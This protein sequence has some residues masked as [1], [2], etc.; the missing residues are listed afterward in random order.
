MVVNLKLD[1]FLL[2]NSS[3]LLSNDLPIRGCWF[4]DRG[5][6][7]FCRWGVEN[8]RCRVNGTAMV[9]F[10][11]W[12]FISNVNIPPFQHIPT[13]KK[14]CNITILHCFNCIVFVFFLNN[15]ELPPYPFIFCYVVNN[16]SRVYQV[17]C[18]RFICIDFC[19]PKNF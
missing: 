17:F 7:D 14:Q 11:Q 3:N 12:I 16:K 8:F 4:G 9:I 19:Y 6:S 13:L 15:N 2:G 10:Q 1:R 5:S 18:V